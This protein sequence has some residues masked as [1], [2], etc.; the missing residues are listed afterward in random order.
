MGCALEGVSIPPASRCAKYTGT[1]EST[2]NT[3]ATAFTTGCWR[4]CLMLLK[5][6]IGS[7]SVVPAVKFVTTISSNESPN[8]SRPPATSAVLSAGYVM[9]RN[10]WNPSAPRSMDASTNDVGVRRNRAI[11]LLKTTRMQKVACPKMI[12]SNPARRPR[13]ALA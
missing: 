13:V 9:Y 1:I 8:A 10:V 7:V 6:Q 3:R 4:G 5:I 11:T 2:I 12:V